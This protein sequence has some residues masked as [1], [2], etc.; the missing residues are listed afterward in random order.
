MNIPKINTHLSTTNIYVKRE[1]I[2]NN[3]ISFE[4]FIEEVGYR[5]LHWHIRQQICIDLTNQRRLLNEFDRK[6]SELEQLSFPF[7]SNL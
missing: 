6:I 5:N 4:D 7:G 1:I 2:K 3:I